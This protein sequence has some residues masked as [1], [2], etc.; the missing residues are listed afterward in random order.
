MPVRQQPDGPWMQA[1]IAESDPFRVLAGD[2]VQVPD[3]DGIHGLD[4][5]P[6]ANTFGFLYPRW[7][8]PSWHPFSHKKVKSLLA[9]HW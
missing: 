4:V 8:R 5:G 1:V 3:T 2:F 6:A 9:G 7:V